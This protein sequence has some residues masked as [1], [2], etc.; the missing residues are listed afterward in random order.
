MDKSVLAGKGKPVDDGFPFS[1]SRKGRLFGKWDAWDPE[2]GDFTDKSGKF[3]E[4]LESMPVTEAE[5]MAFISAG[6][7]PQR[8]RQRFWLS[9]TSA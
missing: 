6:T 3:G 7:I 8:V 2:T 4:L 5:A 1:I 9:P